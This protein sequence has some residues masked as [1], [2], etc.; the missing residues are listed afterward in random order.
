MAKDVLGRPAPVLSRG[1]RVLTL[2]RILLGTVGS[3]LL[4]GERASG[5]N[6]HASRSDRRNPRRSLHASPAPG[7]QR[8][9]QWR[10]QPGS[11]YIPMVQ[12][13]PFAHPRDSTP[14]K[15]AVPRFDLAHCT[16]HFPA[17]R[18]RRRIWK[19][20][21]TILIV[22]IAFVTIF[23]VLLLVIVLIGIRQ[24][25]P[26]EELSEQASTL[27]GTFVRGLLGLH[28]H[29]PGSSLNL[30]QSYEKLYL[31]S[32][33]LGKSMHTPNPNDL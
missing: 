33:T 9:G 32:M 25:P 14:Y 6:A 24:E 27:I 31:A 8:A 10:G 1:N 11:A 5:G 26:T 23:V 15:W 19:L 21:L 17:P 29:K 28:V 13:N 3:P 16:I 22:L 12:H 20:M 4:S 7:R 18:Y 2:R 30:G